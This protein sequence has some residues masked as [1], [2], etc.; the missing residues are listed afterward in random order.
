MVA[1]NPGRQHSLAVGMTPCS[2]EPLAKGE[3]VAINPGTV[4]QKMEYNEAFGFFLYHQVIFP[5]ATMRLC[6][7]LWGPEVL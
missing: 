2:M 3:A 7:R 6:Q 5:E 1:I 4:D